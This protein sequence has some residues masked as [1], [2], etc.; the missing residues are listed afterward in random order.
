[1]HG[2]TVPVVSLAI[3]LTFCGGLACPGGPA[4]D[5]T[6]A[7]GDDDTTGDDDTA[8]DDSGDDDTAPV[9]LTVVSAE[10]PA[11]SLD[12]SL[13]GPL[14]IAFSTDVE[15]TTLTA[16]TVVLIAGQTGHREVALDYDG[17]TRTLTVTPAAELWP[18]EPLRLTLTPGVK[19]LSGAGIE[20]EV[21]GS[22]LY[23]GTSLSYWAVVPVADA[24]FETSPSWQS[25]EA[26]RSITARFGD[27][28]RDGWLDV[29]VASGE[30]DDE[31]PVRVYFNQEGSLETTASWSSAGTAI[32]FGVDLGD[33]DRDGWL[34]AAVGKRDGETLL[35][36]NDGAG[37]LSTQPDWQSSTV[38]ITRSVAFG[39]LQNDGWLD[40]ATANTY[41][42]IEEEHVQ[43]F[44]EVFG[45][46]G[47]ALTVEP[48][49]QSED[50]RFSRA[51]VW[52]DITGDGLLD[53]CFANMWEGQTCYYNRGGSFPPTADW[54]S[55]DEDQTRYIAAHDFD[56]NGWVD[57][58]A[59]NEAGHGRVYLNLG[60]ELETEASWVLAQ[61]RKGVSVAASDLNGDGWPDLVFG[62]SWEH[63][64]PFDGQTNTKTAYLMNGG[65]PNSDPHWTSTD[66]NN[67]WG[68]ALGDVD[69][70]G[71]L[72]LFAAERDDGPFGAE[73][74]LY[75]SE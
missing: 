4:D 35:F 10:P 6:T 37:S 28:D 7:P 22:P 8:D 15:P 1:M 63:T 32:H 61:Y 42:D 75:L 23:V 26:D 57:L 71:D 24:M 17:G 47:G 46:T 51:V 5:D 31:D 65:H 69:R 40:L 39:D 36:L 20:T 54:Q 60:G 44:N 67:S 70:D 33:V 13:E 3:L 52:A 49:W 11:H 62:H 50:D 73:N 21:E 19:D 58:A 43:G 72:D 34:D 48:T 68:L 53:L 56:R 29:A 2:R 59:T 45:N 9:P 38:F 66:V 64:E 14:Q 12:V 18:G 25:D 41:A 55:A 27:I 30:T 16:E 74:S